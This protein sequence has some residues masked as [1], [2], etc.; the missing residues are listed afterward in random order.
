MTGDQE[1]TPEQQDTFLPPTRPA[2]DMVDMPVDGEGNTYLHELCKKNAPLNLIRD[3]VCELGANID[4]VNKDCL[5]PLGLA[6]LHAQADVISGLID[7]GSRMELKLGE[8]RMFNALLLAAQFKKWE[9][10]D[11]LL[12][13]G[14]GIC[15]NQPG[16]KKGGEPHLK[17]CL[18]EAADDGN[19]PTVRKLCAH[20][21]FPDIASLDTGDE[22]GCT[23]LIVAAKRDKP[24]AA[25]AL[26]ECGATVDAV[27]AK[28]MTALHHAAKAGRVDTT[29]LLIA[30]G[31]DIEAR[32]DDGHT[33]L[34]LAA[35]N[36]RLVIVKAL[37]A[38][39]ALLD[40]RSGNN[41]DT[42]LI[43][44][45]RKGDAESALE[46]LSAGADPL[47]TDAFNKTAAAHITSDE[48]QDLKKLL[49]AEEQYASS[50]QFEA[51]YK[52]LKK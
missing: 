35:Q 39:G 42:A 31:A 12:A 3:A 44:A 43:V 1:G 13:H 46:L 23:P 25:R 20:G 15:L 40:A 14:G 10:A 38:A 49:L 6:I 22:A 48:H 27:D 5:P 33:P 34:M 50:R 2:Q 18:H 45:A 52:S 26:I 8:D 4:A 32:N 21:A 28:G 16:V 36:S 51:A 29:A 41:G 11:V 19:A 17:F 24:D 47:L 30:Q 9:A 37:I 7:L